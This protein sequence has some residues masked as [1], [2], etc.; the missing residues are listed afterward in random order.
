MRIGQILAVMRC[1]IKTETQ[2]NG[3]NLK[4]IGSVTIDPCCICS[5]HQLSNCDY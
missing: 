1:K 4:Y 2:Q 5:T 3:N